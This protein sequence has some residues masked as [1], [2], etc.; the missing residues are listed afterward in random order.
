MIFADGHKVILRPLDKKDLP[1]TLQWRNN[2]NIRENIQGYRFPVIE[3]MEVKWYQ[4][5][6]FEQF[7]AKVVFAIDTIVNKEFVGYIHLSRIDWISRFCFMGIVIGPEYSRQGFG[8]DAMHLLS[9]YA[10]NLLNLRKICLEVVSFNKEAIRAYKKFGFYEE[11]VQRQQVYLEQKYHDVH[12][13][14][15]LKEDYFSLTNQKS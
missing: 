11:G 12:L 3:E 6:E 9:H 13:M 2:P 15:L 14:G 4:R 10:F 8:L 5:E 1:T 7:P